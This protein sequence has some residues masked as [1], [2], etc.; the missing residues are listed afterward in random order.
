MRQ[1]NSLALRYSLVIA[2]WAS[3]LFTGYWLLHIA[4]GLL[5]FCWTTFFLSLEATLA[6]VEFGAQTTF[7]IL[8]LLLWQ[9]R[10]WTSVTLSICMRGSLYNSSQI[11]EPLHVLLGQNSLLRRFVLFLSI[12]MREC[13]Y[14]S[15]HTSES[16]HILLAG[17]KVVNRFVLLFS[18]VCV[19]LCTTQVTYL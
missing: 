17:N 18:S 9:P 11:S 14:K 3:A 15:S 6:L 1:Q 13:L 4:M 12:C 8:K 5:Y 10:F 19:S 2:S 7:S 16:L